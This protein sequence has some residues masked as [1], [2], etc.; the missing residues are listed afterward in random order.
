M[1]SLAELI[2]SNIEE[3]GL[4][5]GE[6]LSEKLIS[7]EEVPFTFVEDDFMDVRRIRNKNKNRL[8]EEYSSATAENMSREDMLQML[9]SVS[10]YF[11]T[12]VLKSKIY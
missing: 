10:E 5:P 1:L 12:P 4:R 3:V 11:A 9:G 7:K 8:H 2:S 6:K